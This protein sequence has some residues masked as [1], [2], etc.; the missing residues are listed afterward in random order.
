MIFPSKKPVRKDF[1]QGRLPTGVMNPTEK[2]YAGRLE[3]QYRAGE[4]LWYKFEAIKLVIPGGDIKQ[5]VFY[6]PDF[7]VLNKNC[8]LEVH[9]VKG[10]W[11]DDARVKITVAAGLFPFRFIAVTKRAKKLG[12]GWNVETF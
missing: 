11:T 2:E 9:E 8:E 6:T 1:A 4:I 12:G 10:Y 7:F 3:L 5:R